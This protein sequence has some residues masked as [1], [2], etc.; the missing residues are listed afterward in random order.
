VYLHPL[1]AFWL[2]D[3]ELKRSRPRWRPAYHLCL[4]SVPLLL[5]VLW[6]K[7]ATAPPLPG[8]DALT[9]RVTQ[10][11][12]A[13]VLEG[14]SN[15]ALVATHT[16]LE[17]LHYGIWIVV[18]PLFALRTAPWQLQAVPLARRSVGWRRGLLAMLGIG[19]VV[20]LLLWGCFLADYPTTRDVY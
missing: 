18:I 12:G 14:V 8:D 6:W 2:L 3:R 19:V 15:H 9:T 16:F 20:M 7:L 10:H 4:C 13:G 5:A 17:M 11:A 1:M